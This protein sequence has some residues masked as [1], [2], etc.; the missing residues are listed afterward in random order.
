MKT[1][2]QLKA[3]SVLK[4]WCLNKTP[5]KKTVTPSFMLQVSQQEKSVA[6]RT[7]AWRQMVAFKFKLV[8]RL[9]STVSF[10]V[11]ADAWVFC[12][13]TH[14]KD[15]YSLWF[16]SFMN[17]LIHS[18]NSLWLK[19]WGKELLTLRT[20]GCKWNS[21]LRFPEGLQSGYSYISG[22]DHIECCQKQLWCYH[23]LGPLPE[24]RV[25]QNHLNKVYK[26]KLVIKGAKDPVEPIILMEL[27]VYDKI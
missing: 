16:A 26:K 20:L 4:W 8:L 22:S 2:D 6:V 5:A 27:F 14:G 17:V 9:Y 23:F 25:V 11:L 13:S 24:A 15:R 10:S 12:L 19:F 1:T 7:Y 3:T 21:D 18:S